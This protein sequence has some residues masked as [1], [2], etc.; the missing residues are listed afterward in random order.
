MAKMPTTIG[1]SVP[2]AT[3][4]GAS[5]DFS[6]GLGSFR[7]GGQI[8]KAGFDDLAQGLD[9][10]EAV[11]YEEQL[12]DEERAVK[13]LD[14]EWAK[15]RREILFGD[16]TPTNQGFYATAGEDTLNG[17]KGVEDK[18]NQARQQLITKAGS[19]ARIRETF[20]LRSD[21]ALQQELE[22]IDRYTQDQRKAANTATSQATIDEAIQ[23]A[24]TYYSDQGK[25]DAA[26]G[27]IATVIASIGDNEGESQEVINNKTQKAISK[28]AQD[29]INRA[30]INDAAQGEL[31]YAQSKDMIDGD[32][33]I[34]IEQDLKS[35]KKAE[36]VE[37]RL[38]KAEA[39]QAKEDAEDAAFDQWSTQILSGDAVDVKAIALDSRLDGRSKFALASALEAKAE[40]NKNVT[41]PTMFNEVFR[42]IHLPEGDPNKITNWRDITPLMGPNM[43]FK[44]FNT[45]RGEIEKQDTA[46]GKT[47]NTLLTQ[48]LDYAKNSL[49]TTNPTFGI[50]DP[51]GEAL[52]QKATVEIM[53]A[54][55]AGVKAG[56]TPYQLSNPD[57][58]D[59]VGKIVD[60]LKRPM[61]E[62][63]KDQINAVD[64]M[65]EIFAPDAATP[66]E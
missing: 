6:E 18:L 48:T 32:M 39:R 13:N 22:G 28:A 20:D 58:P 15:K 49:T 37:Q 60:R 9:R 27:V 25:W 4:R 17:R 41:N 8:L 63:I 7:R 31:L 45:L 46:E 2:R 43:E 38:R 52:L 35:A 40:S 53:M 61:A 12:K 36:E 50:K 55:E 65:E 14:N 26:V 3:R 33:R 56:K 24:S 10:A 44:D 34:Q 57:S 30:L 16:G 64:G 23:N 5:V 19:N 62:M 54:W 51:K 47:Q 66:Q 29:R 42:R 21:A 11:M 59:Y 1:R